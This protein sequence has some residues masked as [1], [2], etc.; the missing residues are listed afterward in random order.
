MPTKQYSGLSRLECLGDLVL[1]LAKAEGLVSV[2][3]DLTHSAF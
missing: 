3:G 1:L 2:E